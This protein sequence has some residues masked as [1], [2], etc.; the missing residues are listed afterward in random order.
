MKEALRDIIVAIITFQAK[1]VLKKY[2]PSVIL[3][4]GSVGKTSTKDAVYEV[5]SPHVFVR[6]SEKSF[7]SDIGVPL[8]ILGLPNG[9]GN[10]VQWAQNIIDGFLLMI[11]RA[12]Y[13][14]WLV[15]EVGA[16]RPGDIQH[17][18]AWLTPHVVVATT[19]PDIPVHVE[20]YESP[21]A[22]IQEELSPVSFLKER[23][24]LVHNSD[25]ENTQ[26]HTATFS[27]TRLTY[28]FA[29]EASV[30]A[31]RYRILSHKG[32][33]T[34]ISFDIEHGE[35][36][37][38]LV[39]KGIVGKT[40]V[41]ALLAGVAT[42]LAVGVPLSK[43]SNIDENQPTPNG[44]LKLIEGSKCLILDD[45]YNASPVATKEALST[46]DQMS[47]QGKKIAVLGDMMELGEYSKAEHKGVGEFLLGKVDLLVTV[48]VRAKAIAHAAVE[49]GMQES[50]V[51]S[52][53]KKEDTVAYLLSV[54]ETGDVVLVKGSQSM[55]LEEVVKT[56]M[57]RPDKAGELLVRQDAEWLAR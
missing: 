51:H 12:P 9:W 33:A 14:T 41:Y 52:F 53:E 55:R 47:A 24:V 34:G 49:A 11:V 15:L 44:R 8:T 1:A 21:E 6:K 3:V 31:L 29:K 10:M 32:V 39:K 20:F 18:L 25:D 50:A 37:I 57:A 40:H 46:L 38:H 17:K 43:I 45:T 26:K 36:K 56:L 4:T 23:G 35:E 28:G 16:D 30:R 7:N 2:A 48:G 54:I 19:F 27:G 42:A 22:V 5:L 13:P